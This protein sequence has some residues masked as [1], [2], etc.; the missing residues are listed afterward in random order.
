MISS[1][2][3]AAHPRRRGAFTLIELLVVVAVITL[4]IAI[5]LPSLSRAREQ[6]RTVK[7]AAGLRQWGIGVATYTSV[8]DGFLPAKGDDGSNTA[9][10]GFWNDSSLWF[11]AIP[12]QLSSSEQGYN[13]LQL[14]SQ[15]LNPSGQPLPM[16]G[17]NSIFVC[18]SA[19]TAM[20][21][22]GASPADTLS[23]DGKYFLQ[24]G[25][26][27]ISPTGSGQGRNTF[28]CYQWNSKL[29]SNDPNIVNNNVV[30]LKM[31]QLQEAGNVILM[32]EKRMRGDELDA[33]DHLNPMAINPLYNNYNKGLVQSK[34]MW[35]RFTT[36]HNQ[37]G[38]ILFIDGHVELLKY[39]DVNTPTILPSGVAQPGDWNHPGQWMWNPFY[40][41][42]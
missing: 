22:V 33:K 24:Y 17:Q 23:A 29:V 2:F 10:V 32:N 7:C 18:P 31:F 12:T 6:A 35:S 40:E 15:P 1:I 4:L 8:N 11:N 41:A 30:C 13:D 42:N 27:A 20:G 19:S 37:G 34:G 39:K 16:G 36:R 25:W 14:Q 9:P 28:L 3:S 38:N 5:L 21:A 26:T